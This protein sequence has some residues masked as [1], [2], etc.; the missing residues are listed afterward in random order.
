MVAIS[1]ALVSTTDGLAVAQKLIAALNAI[2]RV[3]Y[4]YTR[5][6][7][8]PV[9]NYHHELKVETY[10]EFDPGLKPVGA[11]FQIMGTG[12]RQVFDGRTY[13]YQANGKTAEAIAGPADHDIT[14]LSPMKN[15]PVGL[16]RSLLALIDRKAARFS[17]NSEGTLEFRTKGLEIGP[18]GLE[19]VGYAPRYLIELNSATSLPKRILHHLANQKDTIETIFR[20]WNLQPAPRTKESWLPHGN[21]K[22]SH[23]RARSLDTFPGQ[24]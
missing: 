21:M 12:W 22:V 5:I 1:L 18:C 6:V 11:R 16:A 9:N 14:T 7:D 10:A 19:E 20:N 23:V 2:D 4:S 15:A 13:F 24:G 8:Y 3:S 17:I